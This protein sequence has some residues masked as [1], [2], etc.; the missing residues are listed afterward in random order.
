L[1]TTDNTSTAPTPTKT[2]GDN[3]LSRTGTVVA[4]GAVLFWAVFAAILLGRAG[5]KDADIWT[6]LT[7]VFASVQGIAFA[8]A[9]AL[10]GTA[11][12]QD[13]VK[14]AESR[15]TTAET[16][17]SNG[18][19]L[20]LILQNEAPRAAASA[21]ALDRT[22]PSDSVPADEVRRRHAA[23]ARSLF[24]DLLQNADNG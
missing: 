11:V 19:A 15:A 13:R 21:D 8:A 4:A 22:P 14:N 23:L 2:I 12:Q 3:R 10:F 17:A 24:G 5:T 7:F 18:R 1:T 20:A 16:A 6:H 9:G